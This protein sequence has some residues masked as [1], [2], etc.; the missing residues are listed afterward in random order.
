MKISKTKLLT[1][2]ISSFFLFGLMV[3]DT[4]FVSRDY[5]VAT[6]G[7]SETFLN[8]PLKTIGKVNSI[9]TAENVGDEFGEVKAVMSS[10]SQ[11]KAIAS[12][13][14]PNLYFNQEEIDLLRKSIL[15]DKDIPWLVDAYNKIKNT[16][17]VG[18]PV[19]HD[20][21]VVDECMPA[22]ATIQPNMEACYSYMI[23]PTAAKRNNL[24][25]VLLDW[26]DTGRVVRNWQRRADVPMWWT[27]IPLAFMYDLL[28]NDLNAQEKADADWF[29]KSS[30]EVLVRSISQHRN[31]AK[32]Y[33][34]V[35]EAEGYLKSQYGNHVAHNPY[36]G[37]VCAL[38]SHD[39]ATVDL[40]F[41]NGISEDY[42]MVDVEYIGQYRDLRNNLSAV[43]YPSGRIFDFYE[44]TAPSRYARTSFIYPWTYNDWEFQSY[45]AYKNIPESLE[46]YNGE[47]SGEGQFYS[48][49]NT[50][51]LNYTLEAALHNGWDAY[52]Y[53]NDGYLRA[54]QRLRN[55]AETTY[56][57]P[58]D[59]GS[60][61]TNPQYHNRLPR[62]ARLLRQY[63][64]DP[65]ILNAF[66]KSIKDNKTESTEMIFGSLGLLKSE[67]RPVAKIT[68]TPAWY[69]EPHNF[70]PKIKGEAPLNVSF[71]GAS[72]YDP[73]GGN[74]ASYKWKI[75]NAETGNA[76]VINGASFNHIFNAGVYY[77][78]LT[79]ID[80][81]GKTASV[82]AE[83]FV[84]ATITS[85]NLAINGGFEDGVK[86]DAKGTPNGWQYMT[87]GGS[88][89]NYNTNSGSH[90]L[91]LVT[92]PEYAGNSYQLIDI[93]PDKKYIMFGVIRSENIENYIGE[94]MRDTLWSQAHFSYIFQNSEDKKIGYLKRFG[95]AGT[96]RDYREFFTGAI[97]PP[98]NATKI[99]IY[100]QI[101][102]GYGAAYFDDIRVYEVDTE[103]L[104][105]T[106]QDSDS[107][108]YDN[109]NIGQ[110][111]DDGKTIDCDDNEQYAYP[112]GTETCD[113]IDNNCNGQTDEGCDQDNDGFCNSAMKIY[114][115]N[116]MCSNT[117]FIDGR[118]GD[119]CNDSSG[120]IN[121]DATEICGN[122]IDDNCDGNKDEG[123]ITGTRYYVK[124]ASDGG[125]NGNTGLSDAQAWATTAKVNSHNF[126]PGD[127]VFFKCGGTFSLKNTTLRIDW[128][129][130]D[131]A[132]RAVIGAYYMNGGNEVIGVNGDGKPVLDGKW[133]LVTHGPHA[134]AYRSIIEPYGA[135]FLIIQDLKLIN[136]HGYGIIGRAGPASEG[137]PGI[138]DNIHIKHIE[139]QDCGNNGISTSYMGSNPLIEYC[140][141][142]GDNRQFFIGE[143]TTWGRGIKITGN[144]GICR[145]NEVGNGWGEGIGVTPWVTSSNILVENNLVWGRQSVGIYL[146]AGPLDATVRN[147]IVIGTTNT[148]YHKPYIYGGRTW[149]P[150][151]IGFNQ[152]TLAGIKSTLRN[153]IYNNIVIGCLTGINSINQSGKEV[154]YA[155][156]QLVYNNTF[157]DNFYNI[158]THVNQHMDTEYKNN[159]SIIHPD[160]SAIG[161]KHVWHNSNMGTTYLPLGNF[162]SSAPEKAGWS[163]PNDIVGDAKLFKTT[164]W[165]NISKPSDIDIAAAFALTEGS[166]AIDTAQ[167]L[168]NEYVQAFTIGSDFNTPDASNIS[169][170]ITVQLANQNNYNNWDFGAFVYGAAPGPGPGPDPIPIPDPI[171]PTACVADLGGNCCEGLFCGGTVVSSSDCTN[172]CLGTCSFDGVVTCTT[173]GFECCTNGCQSGYKGYLEG[174]CPAGEVCCEDCYIGGGIVSPPENIN[175]KNPVKTSIFAKIIENTLMWSLSIIGS[176]AL[177]MLIIG[178]VM[179]IGSAGDEQK[180]LNAKKIVTYA[181]LG[182]IL[183]LVSYAVVV[184]VGGILG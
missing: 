175:I 120:N 40:L 11:A 162:W 64:N 8:Q 113:T 140:K 35:T 133:D 57:P 85:A 166:D 51:W 178:G 179:Y 157:I 23:E 92:S 81:E 58:Q 68:S 60:Y 65:I 89:V 125:D 74:I 161:S 123:C 6:N 80:N 181:I 20:T 36:A 15:V 31:T 121:P 3:N 104:P 159:L 62:Y 182:T 63:P 67:K 55:Y 169:S 138:S 106:C 82:T 44:R 147:N 118:N 69:T 86:G 72:S 19:D 171:P 93:S 73:D 128:G 98:A 94:R 153:K 34:T 167:T 142:I 170:P 116:S 168:S 17:P 18:K 49:F 30:A 29:F 59:K 75:H 52:S 158:N 48:E 12:N 28:Y 33:G 56:K 126:N 163:H 76:K 164:G 103:A 77:V 2:F 108:G 172:C 61:V 9:S 91:K 173:Q 50:W 79:V 102:R 132:N 174:T 16:R 110:D 115:N 78:I 43:I 130:S 83:V 39:Q 109:C 150:A 177:L 10:S 141:V 139:V 24:K 129:G 183:I 131:D 45:G 99:I 66:N 122:N 144:N 160:A 42:F 176:L 154:G 71:N 180:V 53:N 119:D 4:A 96:T 14:H 146:D 151:G 21:C 149:N 32:N 101:Q 143:S 54:Y 1:L 38:M 84:H 127:N 184:V 7:N 70:F 124:P 117:P 87:G 5:Y 88:V 165:Q 137:Y 100:C 41:Q 22:Y 26:T 27:Q 152:E 156:R 105:F 145:Y 155:N 134:D 111:G 97:T 37:A 114:R 148:D 25:K 46:D 112:G 135:E 47:E 95:T 90:A 13:E 136:S 107:D